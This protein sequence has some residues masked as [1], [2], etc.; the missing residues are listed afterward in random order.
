MAEIDAS[1]LKR[2]VYPMPADV[3]SALEERSLMERYRARPA[4]QQNDYIGWITRARRPD[5]RRKRLEQMLAELAGGTKYM[6]MAYH[7]D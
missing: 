4:Y 1:H 5:T 2:P 7:G 6:N 3:L